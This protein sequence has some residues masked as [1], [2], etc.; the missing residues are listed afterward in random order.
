[1]TSVG[2]KRAKHTMTLYFWPLLYIARK[3]DGLTASQKNMTLPSCLWGNGEY[4]GHAAAE[5]SPP[6]EGSM[7]FWSRKTGPWSPEYLGLSMPTTSPQI[8]C[9]QGQEG[10][11]PPLTPAEIAASLQLGLAENSFFCLTGFL[12]FAIFLQGGLGAF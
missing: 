3:R 5:E 1:M 2:F 4:E 7:V 11:L 6:H 8:H 9:L 10:Y 12:H